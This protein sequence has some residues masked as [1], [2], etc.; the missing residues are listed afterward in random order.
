MRAGVAWRS[1][2]VCGL[3]MVCLSGCGQLPL[4]DDLAAAAEASRLG[5]WSLAE[6]LL[7]RYLRT[8]EDPEAR[9]EA[10]NRLLDVSVKA[11]PD[12][13]WAVDYLDTMLLEFEDSGD[14]VR[15][16]LHRLALAHEARGHLDR[17]A[18]TWTRLIN[19]P[20]L[21][22]DES[23]IIHRR[24]ARIYL[25]QR[26]FGEAENVLQACLSLAAAPGRQAECLYDLADLASTQEYFDGAALL[27][28]Q[29]MELDGV[30]P[31][32]NARAG[33]ILAD[34]LEQQGQKDEA[35]KQFIG[36]RDKYPNSRVID[37]RIAHLKKASR[38]GGSG[39]K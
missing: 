25:R 39:K 33:F 24:L 19:E 4:G 18:D 16:I 11:N 31:L 20:D 10:W 1:R 7:E 2:L 13:T 32:L 30:D 35:M 28:R 23:A 38:T 37:A 9:W 5:E 12:N 34:A 36:I 21:Q 8:A 27:A 22:V 26:R 15:D 17:A 3:L 14:R 6:K 29:V